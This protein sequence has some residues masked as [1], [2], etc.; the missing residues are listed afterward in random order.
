[1]TMVLVQD[2]AVDDTAR[3][4]AWHY[5]GDSRVVAWL[6]VIVLVAVLIALLV[7]AR[8]PAL[9]PLERLLARRWVAL[10]I[11][12]ITAFTFAYE[13]G[14]LEQLPLVHD[15]AAYLLQARLFA[16]GRWTDSAPIPEFFEQPHVLV[17]PR[18]AAKY[19]PGHALLLAPGMWFGTPGLVPVIL[20]GITG[21]LLYALGRRVVSVWVGLFAWLV[22][23]ALADGT[24]TFRPSYFSEISTEALWLLG[25]WALLRW[26]EDRR[27]RWLLL[28]A[29]GIGW[30]AITRPLTAVAF[31]IPVAIVVLVLVWRRRAWG[32]LGSACAVGIAILAVIPLWSARTT[33]SWRV[34]PLML[35]TDQYMPYDVPGFGIRERAPL[36]EPSPEIACFASV[37]GAEHRWHLPSSIPRNVVHRVR[38]V[39]AEAYDD[40]RHGLLL[41]AVLGI[42]ASPIELGFAIATAALL[43]LAYTS[44]P[45]SPQWTVYYLETQPLLALL[46][47]AGIWVVAGAAG[48]RWGRA[49]RGEPQRSGAQLASWCLLALAVLSIP[50]TRSEAR[51]VH[52]GKSIGDLPHR[53]FRHSVDSLPGR[54]IVFVRYAPGEACQQN[55]I[56]NDPPLAR[57]RAWIVYDRG[58]DDGRLLRLAPD[59][60][61]YLFDAKRGTMT[62]LVLDTLAER[63]HR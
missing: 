9:E 59:R 43:V 57:A 51:R 37:F 27:A 40:R 35:Y 3:V 60:A 29:A 31:A 47:A 8:L 12:V 1:M 63:N 49:D 13:W 21:A 46:A 61:P 41:F 20:L 28:L 52:H 22:W 34:S 30:M 36:R 6:A 56:E 11:G 54:S 42:L 33:G 5:A 32:Q 7:R 62:P 15:E 25:W 45:H 26:R 39:L 55:L 48:R 16:A 18:Y 58:V 10:A 23:L 53:M 14:T 19:P 44:Y 24:T 17:T 4:L 38:Y 50:A 2:A